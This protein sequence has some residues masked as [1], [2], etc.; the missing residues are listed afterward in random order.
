MKLSEF[1][2]ALPKELIAQEPAEPRDSARLLCVWKRSGRI[3]HRIF[4]ELPEYFEMGDV[5]VLNDTKVIPAKIT[6]TKSTGGRVKLLFV[7]KVGDGKWEVLASGK[8][9]GERYEVFTGRHRMELV[10]EN[11]S[12][13]CVSPEIEEI[14]K[15]HGNMPLPPYIKKEIKHPDD[16][17]TVYA[18]KEGSIAAP[19]A[20]LHF[21]E[22][23]LNCLENKGVK[24]VFL[25]LHVG[26]G[27]FHMPQCEE[28][29][30]H[31]ME[32]EWYSITTEVADAVNLARERGKKVCGVGTT[33]MRA[34]ESA[35]KNGK[36]TPSSGETE[37]F[38]YPGY[39]FQSPVNAFI[40]N[41][42]LPKSTPLLLTSAVVGRE[43]L[44]EIYRIA[45][46]QRYRFFSFGDAM[47]VWDI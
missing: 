31:K 22:E 13:I 42:H 26:Y 35:S 6:V 32:E 19:T 39:K 11:N 36:V 10:R 5:I 44:M 38:I 27:T 2:F 3:E 4:R 1:D 14:L 37:L 20:G 40:T 46:E 33:T 18:R 16:Y 28:V 25:T 43:F 7:K 24:I 29:E 9:R 41:F 30:A 21:T 15:T 23:L 17:Q 47:A 34:L 8:L 45:V 12:W